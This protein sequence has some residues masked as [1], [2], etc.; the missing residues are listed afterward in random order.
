[1]VEKHTWFTSQE[2]KRGQRDHCGWFFGADNFSVKTVYEVFLHFSI[3][4]GG[5]TVDIQIELL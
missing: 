2:F 4:Y 1:M 3:Q 5:F